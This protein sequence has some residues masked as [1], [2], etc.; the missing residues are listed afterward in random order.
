V[1]DERQRFEALFRAH[2]PAL[3]RYAVRRV[4]EPAAA[5]VVA[6]AFLVA[7]RRLDEVPD[8][9]LPW[10]YGVARRVIANER[11]R[12]SRAE[13]LV[14]RIGGQPPPAPHDPADTVGDRLRVRAALE[15]LSERDREVLLLTEW[16]RLGPADAAR[17]LGCSTAAYHVRLHRARRRIAD[18]LRTDEEP[19][20]ARPHLLIQETTP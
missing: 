5:E 14:D 15:R 1:T 8:E 9:P 20:P 3:T 11:R 18:L 19:E 7:W 16:E 17:V 12:R 13:R 2:Y 10:L 6:E 4:G